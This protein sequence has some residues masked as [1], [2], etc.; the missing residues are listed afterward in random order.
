MALT[1]DR[2]EIDDVGGDP[3]KLARSILKQLP[4][5]DHPTPVREIASA[6]DITEI[7]E[8]PLDGLE[9]C[10]I[11]PED[12]SSGAILVR[13]DRHETR[14]RYTIAHE[15]GH[16]VNPFHKSN[17]PDGFRCRAKDMSQEKF[18][19]KDKFA[20]MEVQA[21]QFAA[22]LLMPKKEVAKFI[23]RTG[24]PD[25][26]NIIDMAKSRFEVSREAAAR[27]YVA[28]LDE[29]TAVVFSHNGKIR[30]IIPNDDFPRLAVWNGAQLPSEAY[31]VNTD[32]AIG[33]VSDW[34]EVA[35]HAWLERSHGMSV[36]EQTLAQ[37]KGYR[38]TLLTVDTDEIEDDWDAP[39][40]RNR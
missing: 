11:V 39:T 3:I 27:R 21:N 30:Y 23:G 40:Y 4:S 28:N 6:I 12:K 36:F 38:M 10:L 14:K 22:E 31:S 20:K 37:Q 2:M 32:K 19:P 16:Y 25:I 7:R 17:S 33:D 1:I 29:P 5:N 34:V 35:G 24:A 26:T 9:G 8:R 13:R 15:L 18:D